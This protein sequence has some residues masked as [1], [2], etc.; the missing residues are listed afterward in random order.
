MKF[1]RKST[2]P[3]TTTNYMGGKSYTLTPEMEL[4]TA[5]VTSFVDNTYYEKVNDRILRIQACIRQVAPE[6]VAKSTVHPS[7]AAPILGHAAF[8]PDC[9]V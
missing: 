7:I 6:F 2:V 1:N 4:Y 8:Y 3:E 9:S 5:A